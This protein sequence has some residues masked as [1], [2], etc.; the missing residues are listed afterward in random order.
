[1]RQTHDRGARTTSAPATTFTAA[2]NK[3]QT[4]SPPQGGG[5]TGRSPCF[6]SHRR[7]WRNC[8]RVHRRVHTKADAANVSQTQVVATAFAAG[9]PQ[10]RTHNVGARDD[11]HPAQKKTVKPLRRDKGNSLDARLVFVA[12]AD[13]GGT[14]PAHA[15]MHAHRQ[16]QT[17]APTSK[18]RGGDIMTDRPA[19]S[20]ARTPS[21]P[22][23]TLNPT[24]NKSQQ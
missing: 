24:Q 4:A 23:S 10:R 21:V 20:V 16:T 19:D 13:R 17:S 14:S 8:A 15:G 9:P 2:Q 5:L 18:T 1:M 12:T 11:I 22:T 3:S 6:C 7:P